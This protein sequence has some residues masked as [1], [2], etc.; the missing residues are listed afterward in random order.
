M[1]VDRAAFFPGAL[2][3][4]AVDARL[5]FVVGVHAS[6]HEVRV[7]VEVPVLHQHSGMPRQTRS[8]HVRDHSR[9]RG[10]SEHI[11]EAAEAFVLELFV[12][13]LEEI[14]D[15][16]HRHGEVLDAQGVW[17]RSVRIEGFGKEGFAF[18]GHRVIVNWM[19]NNHPYTDA[20]SRGRGYAL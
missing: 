12:Y 13:V 4:N 15:V 5:G 17:E 16:L 14:V 3:L 7:A 10:R 2:D 9:H 8:N 6:L 11:I 20:A 1:G 19:L 18:D